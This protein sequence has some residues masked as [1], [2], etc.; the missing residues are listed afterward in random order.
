MYYL[1]FTFLSLKIY[2]KHVNML[3]FYC[4]DLFLFFIISPMQPSSKSDDLEAFSIFGSGLRCCSPNRSTIHILGV[5]QLSIL[6][7]K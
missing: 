3:V 6:I 5:S 7:I 4:M 2:L 1:L